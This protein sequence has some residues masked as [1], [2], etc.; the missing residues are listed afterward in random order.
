M[1][2]D[3]GRDRREI[4][5]QASLRLEALAERRPREYPAELRHDAAR[6]VDAAA[7]SEGQRQIA[8][9]RPQHRAEEPRRL[10]AQR[11][12]GAGRGVGDLS[13]RIGL[14]RHALERGERVVKVDEPGAGKHPLR[15]DVVE[16]PAQVGEHGAFALGRGR[17]ADMPTLA[18]ERDPA[19][20]RRWHEA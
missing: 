16:L 8:G 7:G 5:A 10:A 4:G 17:H 14:G 15:R 13:R 3:I 9:D 20:L 6:D 19:A 1:R 11:I 2:H 18:D 12:G